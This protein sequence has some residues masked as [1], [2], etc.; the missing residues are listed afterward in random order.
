MIILARKISFHSNADV[1]VEIKA[2]IFRLSRTINCFFAG[3]R[4]CFF[5]STI[6]IG[7]T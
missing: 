7:I 1:T 3:F 2:I 4:G 6:R 5:E